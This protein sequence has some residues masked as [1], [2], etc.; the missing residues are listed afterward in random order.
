MDC[1]RQGELGLGEVSTVPNFTKIQFEK[2]VKL[3]AA[4]YFN[5]YLVTENSDIYWCGD[6]SKSHQFTELKSW[7]AYKSLN[8]NTTIVQMVSSPSSI[9]CLFVSYSPV[10]GYKLHG[11]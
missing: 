11:T 8:V 4:N 6:Q 2:Q 9:H 10:N 7:S 3:L 1:F 5:S